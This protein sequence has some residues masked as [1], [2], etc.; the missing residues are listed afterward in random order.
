MIITITGPNEHLARQELQGLIDAFLLEHGDMAL[1]R[2]DG[3]ETSTERIRE[4]LQSVPFL[5]SR[6]MVVLRNPSRQKTFSEQIDGV[7]E[8]VFENTDVIFQEAKL[9]KRSSYYKTLKKRTDF[10]EFGELD[11]NALATWACKYVAERGGA[12]SA[13]DARYLI[14]R[15]SGAQQRLQHELEKLLSY[16]PNITPATIDL[17]VEPVASS[18]IFELLEAAFAHNTVRVFDLYKEQRS[19]KVEPQAIIALL[20]WQLHILAVVKAGSERTPD[21]IAKDAALNPFVVRKSLAVVKQL[22]LAH[23]KSLIS[24]LLQLDIQLKRTSVDADEALQLYL[25]K[26]AN[27]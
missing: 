12:L 9:D 8:G 24:D 15:T 16:G 25:L 2:F 3:D 22:S 7:L 17:L 18:T 5:S 1:E 11:A 19:L 10:R 4:S 27:R 21:T 6:K 14:D 13:K 23:I 26:L 20:A